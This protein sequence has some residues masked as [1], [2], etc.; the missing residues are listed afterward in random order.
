MPSSRKEIHLS[1][2]LTNHFFEVTELEQFS[3]EIKRGVRIHLV[4]QNGKPAGEQDPNP[5]S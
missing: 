1:M 3:L 4:D 5:Q 2:T